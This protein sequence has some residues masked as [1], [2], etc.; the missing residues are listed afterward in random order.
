MN[1]F[2]VFLFLCLF[3]FGTYNYNHY[4]NLH[5]IIY[6]IINFLFVECYLLSL[7]MLFILCLFF[8]YL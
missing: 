3:V 2:F 1:F 5:K 4:I 7:L 6:I 8:I